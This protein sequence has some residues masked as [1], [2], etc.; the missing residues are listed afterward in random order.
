[1]SGAVD[2]EIDDSGR[3]LVPPSLRDYA[4]LKKDVVWA[5]SGKYAELWDKDAWR[6]HFETSDDERR[7]I[8]SRLAELGL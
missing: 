6:Q 5:G 2:C 4:Q 8:G 3:I 1:V 7:E